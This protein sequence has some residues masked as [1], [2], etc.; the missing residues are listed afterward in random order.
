MTAR[1]G[2]ASGS[3][4]V[5]GSAFGVTAWL[6]CITLSTRIMARFGRRLGSVAESVTT[7]WRIWTGYV[8]SATELSTYQQK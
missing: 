1:V 5:E 6:R 3:K 2:D 7:G 4:S 8:P